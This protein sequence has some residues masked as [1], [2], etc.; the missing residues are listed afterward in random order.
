MKEKIYRVA[1]LIGCIALMFVLLTH[2]ESPEN[3]SLTKY[4]KRANSDDAQTVEEAIFHATARDLIISHIEPNK[5]GIK[6]H[7]FRVKRNPV[8][9]GCFVYDLAPNPIIQTQKDYLVWWV[10]DDTHAYALNGPS[11]MV[12]PT[13]PYPREDLGAKYNEI[14]TIVVNYTFRNVP[15]IYWPASVS[16][17]PTETYTVMEYKIYDYVINASMPEE[18]AIQEMAKHYNISTEQVKEICDKVSNILYKNNWFGMS[19]EQLLKQASDC[20]WRYKYI[21]YS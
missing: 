18:K 14:T 1:L 21:L 6:G 4:R 15:I 13:L 3:E 11:K 19:C 7:E 9:E 12:T 16:T 17:P 10:R 2:D 5:L 8:G 20:N